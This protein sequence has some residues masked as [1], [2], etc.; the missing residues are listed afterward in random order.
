M[1]RAL[2]AIIV[3]F[4]AVL[5]FSQS[6]AGTLVYV[7][8]ILS[9]RS[10]EEQSALQNTMKTEIA[11]AGYTVTGDILEAHYAIICSIEDAGD[12]GLALVLSLTDVQKEETMAATRLVFPRT[13]DAYASLPRSAVS[14]LA[15]APLPD[16]SPRPRQRTPGD[17]GWKQKWVFLNFKAG[18]SARW[19]KLNDAANTV[20][21]K[22]S[23]LFGGGFEP[24]FHFSRYFGFQ[25]GVNFDWD[26]TEYRAGTATFEYSTSTLRVP[27]MLKGV[28]H[29]GWNTT[30]GLYGGGYATFQVKGDTE[31]P[32][33]GV[34]GGLDLGIKAGPGAVLLDLRFSSDIEES[35][36]NSGTI[37]NDPISYRRMF[38]TFSLGYKFGMIP[39]GRPGS[40]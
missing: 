22:V 40:E 29:P 24:E 25:F 15:N 31:L 14:L 11:A 35:L 28:F 36:I 39:R 9:A 38:L 19:F 13:E 37:N 23:P 1:K 30:L 7:L 27:F 4:S 5:V 6:R 12:L 18:A 17:A 32:P 16:S 8:D 26:E 10:P 34:L 20:S 3:F 21:L 2:C 33:F